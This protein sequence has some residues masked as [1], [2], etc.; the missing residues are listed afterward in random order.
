M[1]TPFYKL[2][3]DI[4][5]K[6]TFGDPKRS[7]LLIHLI[8]ALLQLDESNKITHVEILNPFN[9]K[10]FIGDKLSIVDIKAKDSNNLHYNIEMQ[11]QAPSFWKKRALYYAS[12]LYTSQLKETNIYDKLNKTI[13]ISILDSICF[14]N[15]T[16]LHNFY[17]FCN[18]RTSEPLSDLIELHFI[19]L[20]KFNIKEPNKLSSPFENWLYALKFGDLYQQESDMLPKQLHNENGIPEAIQAMQYANSNNHV[21][22][23]IESRQ[24]FIH[25]QLSREAE[26]R[27]EGK[28]EGQ[29]DGLESVALNLIKTT[30]MSD[31]EI[32]KI[33]LLDIHIINKLRK[34]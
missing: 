15:I 10:E 17:H 1:N 3:N 32:S 21:R 20:P 16:E 14:P 23:L 12:K 18:Q 27:A 2:T 11:V 13:S 5:F 4:L 24:K 28:A 25:D 29:T 30:K 31:L 33:S 34:P 26:V 22:E 6:R 9:D 7:Q 19:E 8:N